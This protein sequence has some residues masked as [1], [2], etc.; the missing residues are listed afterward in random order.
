MDYEDGSSYEGEWKNDMR[1]G[2]GKMMYKNNS[3]YEG[4]WENGKRS[5]YG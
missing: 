1:S 4:N 2:K 3:T 5:G